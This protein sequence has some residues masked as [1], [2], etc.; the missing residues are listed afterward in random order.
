MTTLLHA[1]PQTASLFDLWAEVY[2]KQ[3][4]PLLLLEERT[5]PRLLPPIQGADVL[6]VGCG[7]GR[8]LTRLEALAPRSLA[9]ADPSPAMLERA[10]AKLSPTTVLHQSDSVPLPAPDASLDLILAS[11]ALSYVDDLPAFA[12]DCA[13]VLRPGGTLLISDM[14]PETAAERNW[15]RSFSTDDETIHLPA[16]SR[17]IREIIAAFAQH[18]FTVAALEEPAFGEPESHLFARTNRLDAFLALTDV[19]AIYLLKLSKPQSNVALKLTLRLTA[20]AKT[21]TTWSTEPLSIAEGRI[22]PTPQQASLDLT[23]YVVLPGLIN[24]HDHLEFA[25]FPNLGRTPDQ[26]K[27]RNAP[28]WAS[29]IHQTHGAVIRQHQLVPVATRLWFGALRNLLCGVTTVCH[30]N[31]LYAELLVPEFPL[32]VVK[33]FAWA[34]SLNFGPSPDEA[35]RNVSP[36]T[37]FILHAAEGIDRQSRAEL[38]ELDRRGLLDRRTVLIHGLGLITRDINLLN[39]RGASLVLC[40]TSNRFLFGKMPRAHIVRQLERA[41]LGSDSP[42]TAAGDLLD[43]MQLL[44]EQ[45][46]DPATL[47]NLVTASPANILDLKHG[48]GSIALHGPADLIAVRDKGLSPAETLAVLALDDIELVM[49]GGQVQVASPTLFERLPGNHRSVMHLLHIAGIQR[50]V[51]APLPALFAS[52]EEILGPGN[53][54]IGNKEVRHVPTD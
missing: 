7:T 28:E 47:Y 27:Y 14:H 5:L 3:P 37:P 41:A 38:D 40:P 20:W 48:E 51:R 8:W 16:H 21:S 17:S 32:R 24:A 6:D 35:G 49:V 10:R 44:R 33:D 53:L 18:G 45:K 54:R 23:G 13:R 39:E 12:S 2:D 46:I 43:E 34:H 30:H 19:P 25:L 4:N 9:G 50:W 15:T 29:E 26:P 42:L 31:P 22:T 36:E 11:F 52:A 1:E